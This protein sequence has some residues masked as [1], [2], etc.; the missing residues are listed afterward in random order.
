MSLFFLL[1]DILCNGISGHSDGVNLR[2]Q[3]QGNVRKIG[4]TFRA[5]KYVYIG[6][7][8]IARAVETQMSGLKSHPLAT[9]ESSMLASVHMEYVSSNILRSWSL[10]SRKIM[11]ND[12]IWGL[13]MKVNF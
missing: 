10:E 9:S 11:V 7:G 3:M 6:H 13:A 2:I 4:P 8:I 5:W 12:E 1:N